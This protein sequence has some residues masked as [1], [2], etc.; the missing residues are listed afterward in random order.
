MVVAVAVSF[1]IIF[2]CIYISLLL[3]M[4]GIIYIRMGNIVNVIINILFDGETI[5]FDASLVIQGY[6]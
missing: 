5:S 4:V 2:S 3:I 1:S 6:S